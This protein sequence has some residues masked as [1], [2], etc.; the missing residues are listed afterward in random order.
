MWLGCER[1]SAARQHVKQLPPVNTE[2]DIF[3]EINC[4]TPLQLRGLEEVHE[5]KVE[6]P[7]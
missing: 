5:E 7:D 6:S 2:I 1:Q 4:S 3:T